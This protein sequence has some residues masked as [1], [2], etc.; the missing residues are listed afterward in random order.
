M[1][2]VSFTF[3]PLEEN[4]Y[5]LYDNTGECVIIDPGCCDKTEENELA[6]YI[7]SNN[8]TPVKLLN[9][10]CH[11]DHVLGNSFVKNKYKIP[12]YIHEEDDQT[13]RAVQ[14][15]AGLYGFHHYKEEL[16]D[17]FFDMEKA[18]TFGNTSLQLLFTPG[19]AP[20]H[21]SFY[22]KETK[23]CISGDA[24]FHRSIGRTD[25]PGGDYNTLIKSIQQ[26]LF[27]LP[28]DTVVYPGHGP[29]TLIADEKKYNPFCAIQ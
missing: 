14:L 12:L 26:N 17:A 22:H 18:V 1:E 2:I 21:V 23:T 19:H 27:T 16:S 28:D 29:E 24:L 7:E 3:N 6:S 9:T 5:I 25:L 13:L 11:I 4:T 10:H 15:Y 20:G 8:L